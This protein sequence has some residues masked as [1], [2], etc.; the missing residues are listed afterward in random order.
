MMFLGDKLDR[1]EV[2]VQMF[3]QKSNGDVFQR[4][5]GVRMLISHLLSGVE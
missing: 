5:P 4:E 1:E 2:E 3:D